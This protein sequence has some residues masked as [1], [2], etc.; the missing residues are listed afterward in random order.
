[1]L[2]HRL[3]VDCSYPKLSGSTAHV[4]V[5]QR[6]EAFR[7]S[8]SHRLLAVSPRRAVRHHRLGWDLQ[9]RTGSHISCG[10]LSPVISRGFPNK[11]GGIAMQQYTQPMR[12]CVSDRALS[13]AI[14]GF[15]GVS[16]GEYYRIWL[17]RVSDTVKNRYKSFRSLVCNG[18]YL[19]EPKVNVVPHCKFTSWRGVE[20]IVHALSVVRGFFPGQSGR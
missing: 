10:A 19:S 6:V 12:E 16:L 13:M 4:F 18:R 20:K 11:P 14:R 7:E 9:T 8:F 3:A 2:S 1:M 15:P 5:D 17:I